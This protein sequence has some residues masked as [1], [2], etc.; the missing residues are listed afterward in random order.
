MDPSS[1]WLA[2]LVAYAVQETLGSCGCDS[3]VRPSRTVREL[4]SQWE[5]RN[6]RMCQREGTPGLEVTIAFRQW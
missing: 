3:K 5:W 4:C 1:S 6:R 2:C